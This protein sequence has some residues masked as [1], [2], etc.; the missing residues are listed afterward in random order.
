MNETRALGREECVCLSIWSLRE[1]QVTGFL[2]DVF[3]GKRMLLEL[4]LGK[5]I[6]VNKLYLAVGLL[7]P[8]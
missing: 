2:G 7:C 1:L 8:Q 3:E 6:F 5:V 4:S